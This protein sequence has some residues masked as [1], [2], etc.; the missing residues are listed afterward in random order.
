MKT[1]NDK[2][3]KVKR[4]IGKASAVSKKRKPA[5]VP[6]GKPVKAVRKK[7]VRKKAV[8]KKAVKT[9]RAPSR[10]IRLKKI[11]VPTDFSERSQKALKYALQFAKQFKSEITLLHV[12]E[13]RFAGSEAGVVD[14]IQLES[15]LRESGKIQLEQLARNVASEMVKIRTEIRIGI[16]YMEITEMADEKKIDMLVVSTHGYTGLK[17]VFM[18]S[19]AERIIRHAPCPVLTV[20]LEEHEFID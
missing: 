19:T 13:V 9:V 3:K 17:H 5:K 20:R 10:N 7:A 15:D 6:T 11:L 8:A 2:T 1:M 4:T 12:V 16:P 14:L 18:G